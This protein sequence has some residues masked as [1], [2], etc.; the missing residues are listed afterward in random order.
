MLK[1]WKKTLDLDS[2]DQVTFK[3]PQQV[4]EGTSTTVVS[5]ATQDRTSPT[6]GTAK[7]K[8]VTDTEQQSMA[9]QPASS[10]E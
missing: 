7:G 6:I 5:Q 9:E 4:G 10:E 2:F 8:E 3:L 1:I